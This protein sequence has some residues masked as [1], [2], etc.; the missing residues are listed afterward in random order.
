MPSMHH[1]EQCSAG[2]CEQQWQVHQSAPESAK[3]PWLHAQ[4]F[5]LAA[6]TAAHAQAEHVC[7]SCPLGLTRCPLPRHHESD[8]CWTCS[9]HMFTIGAQSP[10]RTSSIILSHHRSEPGTC[11]TASCTPD[12]QVCAQHQYH[13]HVRPVCRPAI[14]I[15]MMPC[16]HDAVDREPAPACAQASQALGTAQTQPACRRSRFLSLL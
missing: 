6:C 7:T 1:L 5:I 2:E 8:H 9:L 11:S 14:P 15:R 3:P 4:V 16:T 10:F 13:R 12:T